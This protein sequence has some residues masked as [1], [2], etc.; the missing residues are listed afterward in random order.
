MTPELEQLQ[1][2]AREK[3]KKAANEFI[4]PEK[5]YLD[6][7]ELITTAF[8]AGEKSGKLDLVRIIKRKQVYFQQV[9]WEASADHMEEVLKEART[10]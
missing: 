7:D 6:V 3:L 10:S 8:L 2:E 1:K 5:F 4:N 9:G